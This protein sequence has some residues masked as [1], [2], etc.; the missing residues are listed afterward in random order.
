MATQ[1][2]NFKQGIGR[3][4]KR[5]TSADGVDAGILGMTEPTNDVIAYN[6]YFAMTGPLERHATILMVMRPGRIEHSE[7]LAKG[8]YQCLTSQT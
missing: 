8:K 7:E 3:S 2:K 4:S 1:L 5:I 6:Q